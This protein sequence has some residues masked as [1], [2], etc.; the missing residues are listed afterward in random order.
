MDGVWRGCIYWTMYTEPRSGG[1]DVRMEEEATRLA[2]RYFYNLIQNVL[3][4]K[5]CCFWAGGSMRVLL[6]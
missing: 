2:Q 3:E 6:C 4:G 1:V 5:K